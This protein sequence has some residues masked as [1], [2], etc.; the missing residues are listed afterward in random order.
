MRRIKCFLGLFVIALVMVTFTSCGDKENEDDNVYGYYM[1]IQSQVPITLWEGDESQGTM[2]DGEFDIMSRTISNMKYALSTATSEHNTRAVN[3]AAAIRA[4]D[5]IYND[6]AT[7]YA[8]EKGNTVCFVKIIRSR[9]V[10]GIAMDSYTLKTYHFWMIKDNPPDNSG[11]GNLEKP[12]ILEG[13]DLGLSVLWANCN[14][15]AQAV[16][17]FGGHYA[18]GDPTGKLWSGDGITL[19]RET[20]TYSWDTPNYGG[21]N[22]PEDI[23][24]TELDVVTANWGDGWRLP[25]LAEAKELCEQCQWILCNRGDIKWYEVIGPNGNSIIIKLAGYYGDDI[26]NRF[27][28]GPYKTNEIGYYW[29]SSIC[30]NYH[31]A[32]THSYG[33]DSSVRTAWLFK[34]NSSEGDLTGKYMFDYDLRALHFS[35]RAVHD[36][37]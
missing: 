2:P 35:I 28:A 31:Y 16:D 17:D 37:E 23:S 8:A 14:L 7:A 15:G 5:D 21:N 4:C 20:N 3:D 10:N 34:C 33:F 32:D 36:K 11:N 27:H 18:W 26:S 1:T 22:P 12:K 13:V 6:Y 24:G 25:T 9:L 19:D 30:H 29:T